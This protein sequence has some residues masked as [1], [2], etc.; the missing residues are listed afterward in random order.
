MT[1]ATAPAFADTEETDAPPAPPPFDD[2]AETSPPVDPPA[3]ADTSENIVPFPGDGAQIKPLLGPLDELRAG[4]LGAGIAKGYETLRRQV[5]GLIG[6]TEAERLEKSVP[7]GR[8]PDGTQRYQYKPLGDRLDREQGL[9]TPFLK[10]DPKAAAAGDTTLDSLGKAAFNQGASLEGAMLSPLGVT[11]PGAS[12][13]VPGLGRVAAGAFGADMLSHLKETVD[14]ALHSDNPQEKL[15]AW[16]SALAA[17]GFGHAGVTHAAGLDLNLRPSTGGKG[18]RTGGGPDIVLP[19]PGEATAPAPQ[20]TPAAAP[21]ISSVPT[22]QT[23]PDEQLAPWERTL[24]AFRS[25]TDPQKK[26]ALWEQ[27]KAEQAKAE[28]SGNLEGAGLPA[29]AAE[30]KKSDPGL[31][32][33]AENGQKIPDNPTVI[34]GNGQEIPKIELPPAEPPKPGDA[35]PA[36]AGQI[37]DELRKAFPEIDDPT[38]RYIQSIDDALAKAPTEA[39]WDAKGKPPESIDFQRPGGAKVTVQNTKEAIYNLRKRTAPAAAPGEP[40]AAAPVKRKWQAAY[41]TPTGEKFLFDSHQGALAKLEAAGFNPSEAE[42][43]YLA[44]D[45]TWAKSPTEIARIENPSLGKV[46]T[47]APDH[48][49]P[50]AETVETAA[51]G[52][53]PAAAPVDSMDLT[54][55]PAEI[56]SAAVEKH[57][58]VMNAYEALDAMKDGEGVTAAQKTKIEDTLKHLGGIIDAQMRSEMMA[59]ARGQIESTNYE[60]ED[61]ILKLGGLPALSGKGS[62]ATGELGRILESG[63]SMRGKLLKLFRKD[64][65]SLDSLRESLNQYGFDFHTGYD[66]L[67]ALERSYATGQKVYS[68][69][70]THGLPMG[71]GKMTEGELPPQHTTGLKRAVVDTERLSRGAEEIP[72]PERQREEKV[73]QDAENAVDADPSVAQTLVSRIVDQGVQSISEHDAAVLLVE[74]TRVMNL[75]RNW[76]ERM[77]RED[78]TLEDFE[79]GS[80]QLDDAEKQLER[81]DQ[82]QRAAGTTWGRLGHMY[83]RLMREDFS[84]EAMEVRERAAKGGPLDNADKAKIAEQAAR[85][86]ELERER[87]AAVVAKTEDVTSSGVNTAYEAT[88]ADLEGKLQ[89]TAKFGKE[90]FDIAH[91]VVNRWEAEAAKARKRFREK[92]GYANVGVD[93]TLILD[94]AIM[95]RAKIG[96]F[97]LKFGEASA[98][99]IA[100]FG[101]QVRPLLEKAWLKAQQLIEK[102]KVSGPVKQRVKK[103]VVKASEQTPDAVKTTLK[104]AAEAGNVLTHKM[105]YDLARAHINAGIH[106]EDAVMAAVHRDVKDFFPDATERD[107][108]RAF[109]EYGKVKFPSADS[110]KAELRELR[111]LVRLG[112][113][114]TREKEGLDSLRTGLQRDKASQGVREKQKQLNELLKKNARPPSAEKLA[115]RDE[116]RKTALQNQIADLDKR[117]KGGPKA[118]GPRVLPDSPAVEDLKMQRDAMQKLLDEIDAADNPGPTPAE[119]QIDAL[120][121]IR[122]RLDDTLSGKIDAKQRPDF[123]PLSDKAADIQAEILA[124]RELVAQMRR[125]AKPAVDV[126]AKREAA[127]IKALEKSI[128]DYAQKYADAVQGK[129][130]VKG[131]VRLGPDSAKVAELKGIIRQRKAM[132]DLAKKAGEPVLTLEEKYN[133]T[134]LK[135]VETQISKIQERIKKGEYVKPT[136]PPNPAKDKAV[137]DAEFRL[138]TEKKKFNEGLLQLRL[139]QRGRLQKA[140]DFSREA[141]NTARAAMTSFDLSAVL[142]QGGFIAIAHPVRAAKAFPAMFRAMASEAGEFAVNREIQSRPNAPLYRSSK[143]YLH[144]PESAVLSK[145]EEAYMSRWAKKIPGVAHSERAYTSFLNR[146]RADSFDAMVSDM[147]K[148][149]VATPSEAAAISNFINVA[150]GRGNLG[151]SAGAAV[152]LNTAF[153]SPR[154]VVSRFELALG[155]PLWKGTGGTRVAIAKEYARF[156]GGVGLLL[157]LGTAA[158]AKVET[159]PRS[160]DFGKL[161]FGGTRVDFLAGLAQVTTLLSRVYTGQTKGKRGITPLRGPG[162]KYGGATTASTIGNFLRT[163]LSPIV[164]TGID[165][166]QGK[167]VIGRPVTP[168]GAALRMLVP[169]SFEDIYNEMKEQGIVKGT[170]IALLSILGAGVQTYGDKAANSSN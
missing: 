149:G 112:E 78:S 17:I 27:A 122:Q 34:E 132:F 21:A 104:V 41:R 103:G 13:G 28:G 10:I 92:M 85:I 119:Q 152:N 2:T 151:S 125:D 69:M 39:D 61:T 19:K 43:G 96:K 127:T 56:G 111:T 79:E 47:A 31:I 156:L 150:T 118:P 159:D 113:S 32:S 126:D 82:A 98:A 1:P 15:E 109:S 87:E 142:R 8:N 81:L 164:G 80:R 136:R 137:T 83:R 63:G 145:M 129:P 59:D 3:F 162:V 88:I 108:R 139:S 161:K 30:I 49:P 146:L 124:M 147:T 135:Q 50:I 73:V 100:E 62:E 25:E 24:N 5:S 105:V 18:V 166:S 46:E 107:V 38:A 52:E 22:V 54:G 11:L 68:T 6:P 123:N 66:V 33:S 64:A 26:A 65:K 75:R 168:G 138:F 77:L 158:G 130:T 140:W 40:V 163:K 72:T 106:G 155:Q 114:I 86:A 121:R 57:G 16:M 101:E 160:S 90:V 115:T 14:R 134:R 120:A 102:E 170:A 70:D 117:L 23:V 167:D 131:P 7:F 94:L 110:D 169:L 51:P 89:G 35:P 20:A 45:G 42:R 37:S 116:A 133:R 144:D 74:R 48:A 99:A 128:D 84:L 44:S 153:F 12:K 53:K 154:Y 58:S 71:P 60:L 165:L 157:A 9:M 141:V 29:T 67:E 91:E 97:G 4:N 95:M 143:L 76:E 93:P 55:T 36:T 148:G